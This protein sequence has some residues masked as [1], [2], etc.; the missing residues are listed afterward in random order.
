MNPVAPF[1]ARACGA[2]LEGMIVGGIV[3]L[4]IGVGALPSKAFAADAGWFWTDW[5]IRLWLDSPEDLAVPLVSFCVIAAVLNLIFER[6]DA[7]PSAW[8]LK[9]RVVDSRGRPPSW[10]QLFVRSIG[11]L[12]N[13]ATAGLGFVWMVISRHR[14]GLPDLLSGTCVT[15]GQGAS[16]Q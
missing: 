14:R 15:K 12:L 2:L 10:P 16:S 4:L 9:L 6:F 13:F 1:W 8:L 5:L 3:A 11:V 7:G